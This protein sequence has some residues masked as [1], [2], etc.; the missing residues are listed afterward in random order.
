MSPVLG[1]RSC[2]RIAAA[3]PPR[4][5]IKDWGELDKLAALPELSDVLFVGNPIY[6]AVPDRAVARLMVLKRLPRLAKIDS[7]VVTDADRHA[8]AKL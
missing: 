5:Q 7:A 2:R 3:P 4:P 1:A 6:D 8:A